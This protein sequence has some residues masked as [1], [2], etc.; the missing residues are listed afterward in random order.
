MEKR[1]EITDHIVIWVLPFFPCMLL[2]FPPAFLP[3]EQGM[4]KKKTKHQ[5]HMSNY[6]K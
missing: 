3:T 4:M 2:P 6:I 1:Q 5:D